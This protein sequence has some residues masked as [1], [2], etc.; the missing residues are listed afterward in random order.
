MPRYVPILRR[1]LADIFT[2]TR[3]C[4]PHHWIQPTSKVVARKKRIKETEN[5][6]NNYFRLLACN[7]KD[8]KYF[9]NELSFNIILAF[10]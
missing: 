9:K 7:S 1:V 6:V 3:H 2:I 5:V 8:H 10:V 4:Y